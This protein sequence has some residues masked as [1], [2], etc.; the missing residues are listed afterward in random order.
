MEYEANFELNRN[1]LEFNGELCKNN[2]LQ[3]DLSIISG[4]KHYTYEQTT[5]SDVWVITHNLNKKPSIEVVDSAENVVIGAYE[6]NN[7]NTVTLRF[8][9]AFVGKAYFN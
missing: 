7:L 6:Y 9:G 1:T 4:D 2:K 5:P 3:A 8:N